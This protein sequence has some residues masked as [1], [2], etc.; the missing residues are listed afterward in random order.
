[1]NQLLVLPLS[2][3]PK[4]SN[5]HVV[6]LVAVVRKQSKL[7]FASPVV[8]PEGAISRIKLSLNVLLNII[9]IMDHFFPVQ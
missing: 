9:P 3:Y 6:K 2:I 4:I 1:M 8:P 7:S 5:F